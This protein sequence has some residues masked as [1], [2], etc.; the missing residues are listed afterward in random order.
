MTAPRPCILGVPADL[1]TFEEMLGK[2]AAWIRADAGLHQ[3]C[4]INPEFIM[5]AQHDPAFYAVLQQS[6]LN[7]VDGWGAV[8]ALRL[9][10]VQLPG[11]VT[12]SDGVPMI[13]ERA[14][15]LGWRLFLLGG[16]QGVGEKTKAIWES[17]HP[18]IQIVGT[19]EGTPH[20]DAAADIIQR[21]NASGADILLVAYG[22]PQQDLWIYTHRTALKVKVA[23]GIGG[24]LDFIAGVLPRA[25]LWMRRAGL[26][27]LYRL[28]LQPKRWRRM[29]RLPAF[30]LL[31]TLYGARPPKFAR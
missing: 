22:A 16:W 25:P 20:P 2:I 31:S 21:I 9:R 18:G 11:R 13:A 24:T 7:V 27:W 10:G 14:A 17:Q 1:I 29:L 15:A 30:A 12:G 6:A 23:L 28:Y 4:T 5:M 19:Y 26:E 3:I 8:W